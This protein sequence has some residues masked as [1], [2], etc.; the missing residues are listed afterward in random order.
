MSELDGSE[1]QSTAVRRT[2][3]FATMSLNQ[4]E[5]PYSPGGFQSPYGPGGP[6]PGPWARL[7]V[8]APV[9]RERAGRAEE[10]RGQFVRADDEVMRE[11]GQVPGTLKG[12]ATDAAV[13]TF[14]Q[15]W[16]AQMSHVKGQ[17]TSVATALRGAAATFTAEDRKRG[18]A[19]DGV[20]VGNSEGKKP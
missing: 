4:V 3:A 17:F 14:L 18:Q 5:G 2:S 8:T 11:T 12:F 16:E 6:G 7:R 10:V 19:A 20:V 15:R 13:T 1:G 9:L